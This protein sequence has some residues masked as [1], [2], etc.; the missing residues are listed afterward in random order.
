MAWLAES[1][2]EKSSAMGRWYL[3]QLENGNGLEDA[4]MLDLQIQELAEGLAGGVA[5]SAAGL[6]V[7]QQPEIELY[8][9]LVEAAR[10]RLAELEL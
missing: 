9:R 4:A 6:L 5:A 1:T 10:A 3:G 8:H 2:N 7:F